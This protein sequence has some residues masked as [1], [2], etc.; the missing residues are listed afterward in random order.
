MNDYHLD[1]PEE[2]DPPQW[3]MDIEDMILESQEIAEKA[4]TRA[5][6]S[7]RSLA[8]PCQMLLEKV[9]EMEFSNLPDYDEGTV[10][11]MLKGFPLDDEEPP[12][13]GEENCPHGSPWGE[14]GHCD[15]LGDIAFDAAREQR[16]FG[17]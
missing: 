13:S 11:M 17:R 15:H 2:P 1:P 4:E 3:F 5:A 14:C 7:I 12:E 6:E 10:E 9:L 8:Q 16:M